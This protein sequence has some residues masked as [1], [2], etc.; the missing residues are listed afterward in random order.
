[1]VV[2]WTRA[3]VFSSV[4]V[5]DRVPSSNQLVFSLSSVSSRM[6]HHLQQGLRDVRR[7]PHITH[8]GEFEAVLSLGRKTFWTSYGRRSAGAHSLAHATRGRVL[9]VVEAGGK[10]EEAEAAF[11]AAIEAADSYGGHFFAALALRDP[12]KHVLDGTSREQEGRQ[13]LEVAASGLACS[14]AEIES[15]VYP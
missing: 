3:L 5:C 6:R 11:E 1:M 15:I 8:T 10:V 13:R 12:C 2:F 14:V 7:P 4:S 9:A